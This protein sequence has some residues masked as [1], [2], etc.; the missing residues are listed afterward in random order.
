MGS[1]C[2][3]FKIVV[4]NAKTSVLI[5]EIHRIKNYHLKET[6]YFV[7]KTNFVVLYV[8]MFSE[9]LLSNW[10]CGPI[11]DLKLLVTI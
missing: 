4:W 7:R 9:R 2:L 8:D 3:S 5:L 10:L 6:R 1:V 11:I